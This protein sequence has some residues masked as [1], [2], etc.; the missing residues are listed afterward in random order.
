MGNLSRTIHFHFR[1]YN[2]KVPK[3]FN[4]SAHGEFSSSPFHIIIFFSKL[5]RDNFNQKKYQSIT[6][7]ENF[8]EK[9][10]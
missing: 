10:A 2:K 8:F 7:Y 6:T 4:Y 5:I 3:Q 1:K 9:N